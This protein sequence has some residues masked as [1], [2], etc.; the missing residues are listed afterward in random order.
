MC[1]LSDV[2]LEGDGDG[3]DGVLGVGGK[4]TT[5]DALTRLIFVAA[6]LVFCLCAL[7]LFIAVHSEAY[8]QAKENAP[9]AFLQD[10][11]KQTSCPSLRM[12]PEGCGCWPG[13]GRDTCTTTVSECQI[14]GF[15]PHVLPN[16]PCCSQSASPGWTAHP[17]TIVST[18]D[19]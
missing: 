14:T 5:G 8:D 1:D 17:Q 3:I 18:T 15:P 13:P 12:G 9:A 2:F 11:S 10:H 7:N 16:I 4:P 6:V 19:G